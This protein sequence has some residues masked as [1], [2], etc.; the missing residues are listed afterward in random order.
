MPFRRICFTG[1]ARTSVAQPFTPSTISLPRQHGGR[2]EDIEMIIHAGANRVELGFAKYVRMFR[3]FGGLPKLLVPDNL[4]A[5]TQ[6]CGRSRNLHH[7]LRSCV[8]APLLL[9]KV[10][11]MVPLQGGDR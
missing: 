11:G 3:F 8:W 7:S 5:R 10:I 1:S 4:T 6:V 9:C 2:R